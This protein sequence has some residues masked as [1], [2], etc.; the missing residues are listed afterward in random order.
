MFSRP[1]VA[2]PTT[3]VDVDPPEASVDTRGYQLIPLSVLELDLPAPES[4]SAYLA[5]RGISITIDDIG[6]AAITRDDAR[7][8]FDEGREAE[9]RGRE[10]AAEFE[11]QAIEQDRQWR[12]SLPSGL[13]WYEIPPDVLPVVAMTQ[14]DRDAQPRR[15]TPLQESLAGESMTYHRLDSTPDDE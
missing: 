5:D 13:P 4:W 1:A 6:R 2:D 3:H 8:L 9:A 7:R 10:M 12:A 15:L 11:R 14:A